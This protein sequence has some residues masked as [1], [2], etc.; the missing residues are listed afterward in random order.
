MTRL[1]KHILTVFIMLSAITDAVSAEVKGDSLQA[2]VRQY[3]VSMGKGDYSEALS[4]ARKY[5]RLAAAAGDSSRMKLA[6][7]YI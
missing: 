1:L 3:S 5:G 7:S 2:L 6:Y 4:S